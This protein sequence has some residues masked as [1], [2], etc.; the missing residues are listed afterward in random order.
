MGMT[1]KKEEEV[2][3]QD[4]PVQGRPGLSPGCPATFPHPHPLPGFSRSHVWT[5]CLSWNFRTGGKLGGQS[6]VGHLDRL[7]GMVLGRVASRQVFVPVKLRCKVGETKTS[8]IRLT[9][10][11]KVSEMLL[12]GAR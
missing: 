9:A 3:L 1:G 8:Q 11:K 12:L 2:N 10:G 6:R 7:H 5:V 4:N